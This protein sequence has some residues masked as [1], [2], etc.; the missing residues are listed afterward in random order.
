MGLAV[1]AW[2]T[3]KSAQVANDQL[4]QSKERVAQDSRKVVSRVAAWQRGDTLII[5]NRNLEA[6][7]VYA[8]MGPIMRPKVVV[9][10]GVSPPCTQLHMPLKPI[11]EAARSAGERQF[12][13]SFSGLIVTDSASGRMW[14]RLDDGQLLALPKDALSP[15]SQ[16]KRTDLMDPESRSAFLAGR[17]VKEDALEQCGTSN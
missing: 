1:T 12:S 5:A 17:N 2:G 4:A 16:V 10:L 9:W 14:W 15:P 11:E 7:V 3:V 6:T 13:H 8:V